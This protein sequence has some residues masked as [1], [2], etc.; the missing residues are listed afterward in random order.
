MHNEQFLRVCRLFQT[1]TEVSGVVDPSFYFD[2]SGSGCGFRRSP[3]LKICK[4]LQHFTFLFCKYFIGEH[5]FFK[6]VF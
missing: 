3:D 4:H 1:D 6:T 2:R 5:Q